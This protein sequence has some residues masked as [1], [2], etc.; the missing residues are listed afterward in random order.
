MSDV[1]AI[2]V[3]G[4]FDSGPIAVTASSSWQKVGRLQAYGRGVTHKLKTTVATIGHIKLQ[5]TAQIDD[6]DPVDLCVDDVGFNAPA[7][8]DER[9]CV[10]A[11]VLPLAINSVYEVR[12][13]GRAAEIYLWVNTGGTGAL[14]EWS[15]TVDLHNP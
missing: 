7:L 11:M 10:P 5:Q 9:Y 3:T 1:I 14:I 8:S 4:K 15:G 12:T 13:D 6:P 2:D